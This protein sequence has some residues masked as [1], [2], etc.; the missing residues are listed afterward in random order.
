ME[1]ELRAWGNIRITGRPGGGNRNH[2]R[3]A[4]A[5]DGQRLVVR[6]SRRTVPALDWELDLL[7]HLG[8]CG[9]TVPAV[10]PTLDGRRHVRG[11][12]VQEWLNGR[13]PAREDW[14]AVA[15]ELRRLHAV[16]RGWSQRPGFR[17]TRDLLLHE[18]GGDVD[19]SAMPQAAVR[20]C[21]EAWRG[22]AG[23]PMAVVHGDPAPGNIRVTPSSVGLLDWDEARVDHVDLDLADLPITVLPTAQQARARAAVHAWEAAC[24]WRIENHY[25]RRRLADLELTR[26]EGGAADW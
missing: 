2:V 6:R 9:F 7:E 14:A 20:A 17:S 1:E 16:T 23:V 12:V 5:G 18:R 8:G 19:L 11:V 13:P 21:R 3:E 25:A 15:T 4:V 24:C 26:R 22:L 10:V